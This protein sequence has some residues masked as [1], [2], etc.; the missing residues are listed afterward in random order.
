MYAKQLELSRQVLCL[1]ML[2]AGFLV[3]SGRMI[4]ADSYDDALRARQQATRFD[5]LNAKDQAARAL[6]YEPKTGP[7][8]FNSP[9][10]PVG[11]P[12]GTPPNG[13]T[14]PS[15]PVNTAAVEAED[16]GVLTV[17]LLQTDNPTP[18]TKVLPG[19]PPPGPPT[20][21]PPMTMAQV[22]TELQNI[23]DRYKGTGDIGGVA[24]ELYIFNEHYKQTNGEGWYHWAGSA[25]V[26]N[27][28]GY[29][30]GI[31]QTY[32][33][34][35]YLMARQMACYEFV[36]F[37][38]WVASDRPTKTPMRPLGPGETPPPGGPPPT[39]LDNN[40]QTVAFVPAG[41]PEVKWGA[42]VH[43]QGNPKP[44]DPRNSDP[45]PPP[46]GDVVTGVALAF[47]NTSGFY[48]VGISTGGGRV[49]GL[50]SDG[51]IDAPVDDMFPSLWYTNVFSSSYAYGTGNEAPAALNTPPASGAAPPA[52]APAAPAK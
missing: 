5:D 33:P 13:G 14:P 7:S 51:L 31:V 49:V 3:I 48:H 16:K 28:G 12:T 32:D 50:G 38:A 24:L 25:A 26:A 46:K 23:S 30:N 52:P 11:A 8:N 29:N 22:Q 39:G 10:D 17:Y 34:G 2:V 41:P 18:G 6:I 42:K 45:G 43:V 19:N 36:D 40:G 47:N 37:C 21:E 15:N 4:Y 27:S 1:G 35:A 44:G 20:P 9:N